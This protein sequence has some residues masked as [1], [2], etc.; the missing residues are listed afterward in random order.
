MSKQTI[1]PKAQ[2]HPRAKESQGRY[3]FFALAPLM[4]GISLLAMIVSLGFI[5]T[6]GFNYGI[7]FV[8]GNEMQVKLMK[9]V[10]TDELAAVAQ[11]A[12][13]KN[14]SVQ[15]FGENNE[16]LI[17]TESITAARRCKIPR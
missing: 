17:R 13:F 8:G 1:N 15:A 6:K 12:G 16:Y 4:G 11:G 3:D 5:M 2:I 7:D 10:N 9:P 14:P